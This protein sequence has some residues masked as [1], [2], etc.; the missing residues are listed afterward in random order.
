MRVDHLDHLTVKCLG[1]EI[2]VHCMVSG[3]RGILLFQALQ[4]SSPLCCCSVEWDNPHGGVCDDAF[5]LSDDG[6]QLTQTT[7]MDML[8]GQHISYK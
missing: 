2:I 1:Q 6:M 5:I 8:D 4:F 3:R 7:S